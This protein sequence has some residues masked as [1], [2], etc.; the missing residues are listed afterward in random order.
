[1]SAISNEAVI[2][3]NQR[4]RRR[5]EPLRQT[6]SWCESCGAKRDDKNDEPFLVLER[7]DVDF[8]ARE[9]TELEREERE[10]DARELVV[11]FA[12]DRGSVEGSVFERAFFERDG[13]VRLDVVERFVDVEREVRLGVGLRGVMVDL[14]SSLSRLRSSRAD[15]GKLKGVLG[16]H[17][18][19]RP[20]PEQ[21]S[22]DRPK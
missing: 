4:K 16:R 5:T 1:M 18:Q 11:R 15:H 19:W 13:D 14:Q 22:M 3:A 9:L 17:H 7:A 8:A 2:P 20:A 12:V 21:L 10:V 6:R